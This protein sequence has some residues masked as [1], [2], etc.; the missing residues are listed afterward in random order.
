MK[1]GIV[2]GFAVPTL[3]LVGLTLAAQQS[4]DLFDLRREL[5]NRIEAAYTEGDFATLSRMAATERR[6]DL[7]KKADVESIA[8]LR[9]I[10]VNSFNVCPESYRYDPTDA[11]CRPE[12][13]SSASTPV[14]PMVVT[15]PSVRPPKLPW[16]TVLEPPGDGEHDPGEP[17][18][19]GA[20]DI[21]RPTFNE[22]TADDQAAAAA[23]TACTEEQIAICNS[24]T[25]AQC[26][27]KTFQC[28]ALW[29]GVSLD[30]S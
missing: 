8:R 2:I 30:C 7:V 15:L 26:Q 25:A 19:G 11:T 21:G 14:Q 18:L 22:C 10:G 9:S 16:E 24:G 6:L 13:S 28:A 23:A 17:G 4:D 20:P 5:I 29:A 12:A 27:A 1:K 3:A